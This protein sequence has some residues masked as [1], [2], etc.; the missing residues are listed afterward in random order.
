MR[1]AIVVPI[2]KALGSLRACEYESWLP[3]GLL[4]LS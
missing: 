2:D 1:R 4:R 3:E